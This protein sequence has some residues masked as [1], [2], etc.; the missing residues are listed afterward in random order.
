MQFVGYQSCN[1]TINAL[2]KRCLCLV[3][4]VTNVW[5]VCVRDVKTPT[6]TNAWAELLHASLLF[7]AAA[8]AQRCQREG[9]GGR[10]REM[11]VND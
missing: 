9:I 10:R 2:T 8:L 3:D 11:C 5:L 6:V 4:L 7:V 1:S